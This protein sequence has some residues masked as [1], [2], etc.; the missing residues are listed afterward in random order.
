MSK[1]AAREHGHG[2]VVAHEH[3][4]YRGSVVVSNT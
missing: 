4:Q 1:D 3:G 2:L